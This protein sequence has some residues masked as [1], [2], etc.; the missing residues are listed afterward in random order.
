M[1]DVIVREDKKVWFQRPVP[2][3]IAPD[4]NEI[5]KQP[6]CCK[7]VRAKLEKGGLGGGYS[8]PAQMNEVRLAVMGAQLL[9]SNARFRSKS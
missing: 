2:I 9:S 1:L 3:K 6:M 4:Y 8:T 5:I 7:M